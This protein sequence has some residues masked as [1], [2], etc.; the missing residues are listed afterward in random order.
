ML[1][2]PKE[3]NTIPQVEE[4]EESTYG[5]ATGLLVLE[6]RD[7]RNRRKAAERETHTYVICQQTVTPKQA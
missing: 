5:Q 1:T 2:K 7:N 3:K 4:K 6:H